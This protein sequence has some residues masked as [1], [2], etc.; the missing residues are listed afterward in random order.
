MANIFDVARYILKK[1]GPM[2]TWKLQ[3]LCYYSQAWSVAWTEKP[4]FPEHFEAWANGPVAPVLFQRHKGK[5][6]VGEKDFPSA[7]EDACGLSYGQRETIDKVLEHYGDWEPY[8]L[9]EQTHS[10]KPW[11]DARGTT[12]EGAPCNTVITLDSMGDYYGGL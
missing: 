10:E 8:E 7:L 2:S 9:R 4:L 12:P 5:F 1:K 11:Q 3:K 6:F